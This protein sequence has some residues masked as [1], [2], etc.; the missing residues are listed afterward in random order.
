LGAET[1]EIMSKSSLRRALDQMQK[2]QGLD[3]TENSIVKSVIQLKDKTVRDL[4]TKLENQDDCYMLDL[5]T[6]VDRNLLENLY[7]RGYS[8]I[9]VFDHHRKEIK[10]ILM[11]KDLIL[12]NPDKD[13]PTV[14]QISSILRDA[15]EISVDTNA[16]DALTFFLDN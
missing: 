6:R 5:Q 10:G 14:E 13:N 9:P 15:A 11:S 3:K 16:M 4:Y 7:E 1:G 2:E 8:R 12:M